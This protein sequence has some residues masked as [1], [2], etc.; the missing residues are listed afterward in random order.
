MKDKTLELIAAYSFVEKMV[1]SADGREGG[2]APYWYG[3][4]L[5]DAFK[6][7]AEYQRSV[8]NRPEADIIEGQA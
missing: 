7:G 2:Y 1:P 4:A 3:W 8:D 6:A 5:Q